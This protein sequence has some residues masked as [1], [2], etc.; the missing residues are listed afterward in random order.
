MY[1][2]IDIFQEG[3]A[4]D[5]DLL[6][7][8]VEGYE[9]NVPLPA[10]ILAGF[11]P[12]GMAA[13]LVAGGKYGRDAIEEFREGNIKPGLMYAG[14]AGLSTLGAIPLVGE[15]ATLVKK[16][17]KAS[18]KTSKG[19]ESLPTADPRRPFT[20]PQADLY[21]GD[22]VKDAYKMHDRA[23]RIGP[24]FKQQIDDIAANLNLST[25]LPGTTRK[26][27][28]YTGQQ[29]GTIKMP[30][31]IVEKARTKTGNDVTNITD[32]I[33][34]RIVINS[35][36]DE[37]AVAAAIASK[38]KVF[39]KGRQIKPGGFVD[40]KI[41]I[42][43]TGSNG[44]TLI[45]E[46]GIITAPMWKA[47]NKS[48]APYEEFRSLFPKG[49]PSDPVELAKIGDDIVKKGNALLEE[50]D[51]VFKEAKDQIDPGFYDVVSSSKKG[52]ANLDVA[53]K[54]LLEEFN[55][56]GGAKI[57]SQNNVTLYHR[58][59]KESADKIKQTGK[60]IGKEDRLYFSTKPSGAIKGYGDELVEVKIPIKNLNIEDIFSDEVHVTLKSNFKPTDVDVKKFASGGYVTAGSSGRSLPI[61]PNLVS[62]S[63]LDIFEPSTKKSATWLGSANV[64]SELPG[65]IKKP[66]YP[67]STG[68]ITAGPSSQP[69]YNVSFS[70]TPSLQK[71]TNNYNPND[72]D[73]FEV[74]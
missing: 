6:D 54:D 18:L 1:Q 40:R 67:A 2:D 29:A 33:R 26:I 30:A 45:G 43:F 38:Y 49:M 71:F 13:D 23:L 5:K 9:E 16:P 57:D 63:V 68:L 53:S 14:I 36:A 46:V 48:H 52:I 8:V 25:V 41:N 51:Q 72:V 10:Q 24:E 4:A 35:P 55:L 20:R 15:L 65:D 7:R 27:D 64:Q 31:R 3:G 22:P 28:N 74:E 19:I 73:I 11:T 37:E 61:T 62:K 12:P 47:A 39:D 17:L 32:P 66:R 42:V 56:R 60:M 70:I 69:K 50:M 21:S 44:E 58:T 59:N 34:T